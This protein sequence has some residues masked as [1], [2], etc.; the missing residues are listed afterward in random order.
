MKKTCFFLPMIVRVEPQAAISAA[1]PRQADASMARVAAPAQPAGSSY[2]RSV[3]RPDVIVEEPRGTRTYGKS[4]MA[5][6]PPRQ[7]QFRWK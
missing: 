5:R 7:A 2:L 6:S 3:V 1:P 4:S